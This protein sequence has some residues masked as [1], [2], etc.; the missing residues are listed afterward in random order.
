[1]VVSA[2]GFVK[3]KFSGFSEILLVFSTKKYVGSCMFSTCAKISE[4]SLI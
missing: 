1:M 4:V 2:I 3:Y